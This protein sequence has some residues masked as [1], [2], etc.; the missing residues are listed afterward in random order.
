MGVNR[1]TLQKLYNEARKAILNG[2]NKVTE[3]V[4]RTLGPAGSNALTYGVFGRS[5]RLTND[6][7]TIAEVAEP[8]D[9]FE[10]L[11]AKAFKESAKR[12]NEKAGD[13]TTTTVVIAGK[14]INNIFSNL[15][16]GS[17]L[18]GGE[19]KQSVM[20]IKRKLFAS[21]KLVTE[22]IKKVAKKVETEEE[23]I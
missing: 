22:E 19:A 7:V 6:G 3:V 21:A 10:N 18:I 13:G 2:V 4:R 5:H 1:P 23:M 12:T 8:L 17:S 14:L 11:A 16:L 20:D 9:E 15:I